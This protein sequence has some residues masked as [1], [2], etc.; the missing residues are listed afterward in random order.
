MADFS[1]VGSH[2]LEPNNREALA[3]SGYFLLNA[4]INFR[5]QDGPWYVAA[6]VRNLTDED[7][8]SAAQDLFLSLGFS[9]IVLGQPRTWG[10][11]AGYRF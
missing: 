1:S 2:F 7:Y 5:P 10:I 3:E 4:R 6:W 8:R 9:E 11:E